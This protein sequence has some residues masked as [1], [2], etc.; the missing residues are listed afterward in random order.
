[1]FKVGKRFKH[2]TGEEIHVTHKHMKRR[3]C[4]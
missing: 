4:H 3:Q 1:M 2:V